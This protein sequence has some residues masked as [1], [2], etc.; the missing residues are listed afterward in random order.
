M[1]IIEKSSTRELNMPA[2]L[3]RCHE[4]Q[5]RFEK[6]ISYRKYGEIS[7]FCPYCGGNEVERQITPVRL[8]IS[9]RQIQYTP[10]DIGEIENDPKAVGKALRKMEQQ[11]ENTLAPE[12]HE[13]VDRLEKGQSYKQIEKELPEITDFSDNDFP[14]E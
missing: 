4:C 10:E 6:N 5:K 8:H 7:I 9:S 1:I 12:F 11:S 3:F 14:S 2:Y 13:V